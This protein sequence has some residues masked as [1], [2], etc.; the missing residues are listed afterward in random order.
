MQGGVQQLHAPAN[1]SDVDIVNTTPGMGSEENSSVG[2]DDDSLHNDLGFAVSR[3]L[4]PTVVKKNER[5]KN[6][7]LQEK[8]YEENAGYRPDEN[9]KKGIAV[10]MNER[11]LKEM[12]FLP[13]VGVYYLMLDFV[14]NRPDDGMVAMVNWLLLDMN[15]DYGWK[16]KVCF[17]I[18]YSQWVRK[19]V[20][21]H[22]SNVSTK[23]KE[24][25][26]KISNFF[27]KWKV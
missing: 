27:P 4:D 26:L 16:Q 8:M 23:L 5:T 9:V 10:S 18:T 22:R 13:K 21:N 24:K 1:T 2:D 19:Q 25:F 17:W 6:I 15:Y 20:T 3:T 14:S 7:R 12:K 11:L